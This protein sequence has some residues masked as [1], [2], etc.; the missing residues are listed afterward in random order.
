MPFFLVLLA[1][2]TAPG[3]QRPA[4]VVKW[5]ASPQAP[6]VA[7]GRVAKIEV[8]AD[9]Q[10]GW[11][12]YAI[13]QKVDGPRPLAFGVAKNS[14]YRITHTQITAPKP[15]I[16]KD[17]NFDA[18]TRYYENEASFTVPVS[19]SVDAPAGRQR[20]PLEITFQACGN[21]IC[22]RPYT[23]KLDVEIAISR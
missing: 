7:P 20:L 11:K 15:K 3:A 18:E 16:W 2:L 4:D 6:V 17:E 13:E 9:V 12:L 1:L 23:Q 8:N 14:P 10:P 19:V 22:L 5:S 21:D